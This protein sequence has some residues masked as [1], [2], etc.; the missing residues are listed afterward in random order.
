MNNQLQL[1]RVEN[2]ITQLHITYNNAKDG[3]TLPLSEGELST[4]NRTL[5]ILCNYADK[6]RADC[7]GDYADEYY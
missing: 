3:V 1:Y 6:L 4:I 2:I 5:E 7:G